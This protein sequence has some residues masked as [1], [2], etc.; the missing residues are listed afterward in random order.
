M[1]KAISYCLNI[2]QSVSNMNVLKQSQSQYNK[3]ILKN[4][5]PKSIYT[6]VT[7]TLWKLTTY[8]LDLI[9]TH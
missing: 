8:F 6:Q 5:L 2:R 4:W 3:L 7:Q 9:F 1:Y